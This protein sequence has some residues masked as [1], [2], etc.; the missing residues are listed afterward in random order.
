MIKVFDNIHAE[1]ET[2]GM[3]LWGEDID[4]IG[5]RYYCRSDFEKA[6]PQEKA[7][8]KSVQDTSDF[9]KQILKT[10]TGQLL[11]N[12]DF[13]NWTLTNA[14]ATNAKVFTGTAAN[15]KATKTLSLDFGKWYLIKVVGSANTGN[16]N[17]Y[18]SNDG[19]KLLGTNSFEDRFI[20]LTDY[21]EFRN[22]SN[23]VNT[24]SFIE[25]RKL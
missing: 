21:I 6:S 16:I 24:V 5:N 23:A 17:C 12:H 1:C 22:S 8:N 20:A 14:T 10:D 11:L 4:H 13:N 25:V 2:C 15:S 7:A 18:N 19:T 3:D 9:L